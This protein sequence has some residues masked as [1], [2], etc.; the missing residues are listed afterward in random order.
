M[1][2][3]PTQELLDTDSGTAAE[4]AASM[5][6]LRWF[7]RWFGGISTTR[8]I[9]RAASQG[10]GRNTITVLD[11]GAGDGFIADTMRRE[12]ESSGIAVR[13]TLLDRS[14]SHLP[15]NGSMTK[16]AGEA[17]NLPFADAS[18]DFVSCSLF[19]HH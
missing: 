1:K 17:L 10:A 18:F 13:F 19:V 7:N 3:R 12:F 2:R 6:D 8:Q 4:V 9:L 16:I 5:R 15:R 14:T 11:V